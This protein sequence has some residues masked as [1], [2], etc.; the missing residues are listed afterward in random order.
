MTLTLRQLSSILMFFL[1]INTLKFN[2]GKLA[3]FADGAAVAQLG[4]TSVLVTAVSQKQSSPQSFLPL[5]VDYRQKAA[6]AGRIP[7][8]HLRRELG[9]TE[10][11]ILTSRVIDRSIRPLF[12]DGYFYSTQVMCNLLAVDGLNDPD[13]IS[14]NAASAALSVS[15]IPWNGPVA[16]VRVGIVGEDVVINPTR[17][18][19]QNSSLNIVLTGTTQRRVV[20]LEGEADRAPLHKVEQALSQGIK[21]TQAIIGK[22]NELQATLGK[23]KRILEPPK[24]SP[25][26]I[27]EAVESFALNHVRDVLCND[28]HDKISRD[29]ALKAVGEQV[30]ANV[31]EIYPEEEDGAIFSSYQSFVKK[32]F[33]DLILD[34]DR[35]C[36]GRGLNNLRDI[37]CSVD[38]YKP[39]HGSALFQRG[40]TQVLCTVTFDSL[41]S[42]AKSDPVSV[43]TGGLKEKNFLLHYEFP[44]YATNETGRGGIGRRELGHGA[45]AERGLKAILPSESDFTTRLTSEVLESNGSSSMASVCGGSLALMDAGVQVKEAA[46]GV[47]MG[48]VTRTEADTGK[49]LQ[50]KILT[51]LLGIEDYMGDMDFKM[52]A[53]ASGLT[54]LQADIKLPGIPFFVVI[55]ALEEGFV[56]IKQILDIMSNTISSPRKELKGCGPVTE[57]LELDQSKQSRLVSMGGYNLRKLKSE[58]GVTVTRV[59]EGSFQVFAPNADA[60]AEAKEMMEKM[61]ED[62]K[63][64]ILEF[65]S[66]YTG[67]ITEVKEFGVMVE[68]HPNLRPILL[69]NSQLDQRKVSHASSLGLDVGHEVTVKYFGRDPASGNHRISRKVL[70]SPGIPLIRNLNPK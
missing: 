39:L 33:R 50:H 29:Q 3:R 13:V 60:M 62:Q 64:P 52:A 31:K 21:A 54:A 70:Q 67:R 57:K 18:Q 63:E 8:N 38:L 12:P 44:P 41:D 6:A 32:I 19:L 66:I 22:I 43:I 11:E 47:A 51:D 59:D 25:A 35:R 23:T 1:S 55:K 5:T 16:A 69:H 27:V 36:D 65:G 26:R 40:Q 42:A 4:D 15:D 10:R 30:V 68:L 48:L 58:T 28:D 46:A 20:M 53:T 14:I 61:M 34:E 49:V 7:T 17:R 37:S 56:A 9:P 45:L 2:T 24:T